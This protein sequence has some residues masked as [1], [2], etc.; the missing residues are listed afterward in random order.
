MWLMNGI[1]SNDRCAGVLANIPKALKG[2]IDVIYQ[3]RVSLAFP[4][5]QKAI[6]ITHFKLFLQI[7]CS[8][9]HITLRYIFVYETKLFLTRLNNENITGIFII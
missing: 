5:Q 8:Q 3:P 2:T 1:R 6:L 9:N 7:N 4:L